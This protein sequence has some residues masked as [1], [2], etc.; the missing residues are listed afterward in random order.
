MNKASRG[1]GIPVELFQIPKE[2]TVKGFVNNQKHIA[3]K[4][5]K[6]PLHIIHIKKKSNVKG[7]A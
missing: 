1:D 4:D 3:Q 5:N 7:K 6:N 2:D